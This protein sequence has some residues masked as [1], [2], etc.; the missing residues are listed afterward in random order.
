MQPLRY[1]FQICL[2]VFCNFPKTAMSKWPADFLTNAMRWR[3]G[4]YSHYENMCLMCLQILKIQIMTNA[5]SRR[6]T[7]VQ[8]CALS[9]PVHY[10]LLITHHSIEAVS[11]WLT[12]F[13]NPTSSN[14]LEIY[15]I[16]WIRV[17][18]LVNEDWIMIAF[19][20]SQKWLMAVSVCQCLGGHL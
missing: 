16:S 14:G 7:N 4:W 18:H 20:S 8:S 1:E 11:M 6:S 13:I 3:Y 2:N 9:V 15:F 19:F 12:Q 17:Q 10:K 5:L